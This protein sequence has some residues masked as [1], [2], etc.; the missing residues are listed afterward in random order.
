MYNSVLIYIFKYCEVQTDA[1]HIENVIKQTQEMNKI[2]LC[3]NL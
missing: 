1:S 3:K 2:H